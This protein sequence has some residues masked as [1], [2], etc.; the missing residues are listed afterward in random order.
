MAHIKSQNSKFTTQIVFKVLGLIVVPFL[1]WCLISFYD[2]SDKDS[3]MTDQ[4]LVII[5]APLILMYLLSILAFPRYSI[6]LLAI[7]LIWATVQLV[8]SNS[9]QRSTRSPT[10]WSAAEPPRDPLHVRFTPFIALC[11][12]V[13]GFCGSCCRMTFPDSAPPYKQLRK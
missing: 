12:I 3:Q 11:S 13:L 4:I 5:Q 10:E 2:F 6:F 8:T 1:L 7:I 9:Q